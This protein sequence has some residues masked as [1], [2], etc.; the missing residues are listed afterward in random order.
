MASS[1]GSSPAGGDRKRC[2]RLK[3]CSLD[4]GARISRRKILDKYPPPSVIPL[5]KDSG[6]SSHTFQLMIRRGLLLW[7]HLHRLCFNVAAHEAEETV[8]PA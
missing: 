4:I 5:M 2:G 8:V 7:F 6:N 3:L 1:V